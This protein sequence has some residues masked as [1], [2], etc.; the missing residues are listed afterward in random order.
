MDENIGAHDA[1]LRASISV[2]DDTAADY[3]AEWD[4]FIADRLRTMAADLPVGSLV[5]DAGCGTGRDLSSWG[6]LGM[7]AIGVDLSIAMSRVTR[8]RGET[9]ARADLR[10]LPFANCAFAGVWAMASLVHLTHHQ[11][12]VA[13]AEL[14]RV[15]QLDG[16]GVVTVKAQPPDGSSVAWNGRRWFSYWTPSALAAAADQ[17]GWCVEHCEREPDSRRPSV[18]WCVAEL[19][20]R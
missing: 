3:G 14:R 13:L 9:V 1:G 17:A 6:Q 19:R 8:R 4:G 18:E 20:R 10:S 15:V 5:L 7:R 11:V 12:T 16:V 2:Y